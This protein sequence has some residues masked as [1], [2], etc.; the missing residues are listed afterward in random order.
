MKG[1]KMQGGL[2]RSIRV[3]NL[4]LDLEESLGNFDTCKAAYLRCIELGVATPQHVL[5]FSAYLLEQ[6]FFEEAFSAYEK[7][8]ALFYFPSPHAKPVWSEYLK[9]FHERYGG[10]KIER[11]RELFERC[12]EDC[13]EEFVG[14]YLMSYAALE[15]E[16]GLAKRALGVYERCAK[17]VPDKEKL[18]AYQL[19]IAK[20]EAFFGPT[21]TR[22]IYEAAIAA[23]Q[24]NDSAVICLAYADLEKRLGEVDRARAAMQ[25]GAQLVDP[26]R[27]KMGYWNAWHEFEVSHG[28]EETFRDMLRIKRSVSAAFSTVNYNSGEMADATKPMSDA[29]AIAMIAREEGVEADEVESRV[30]GFVKQ[31]DQ[32]GGKRKAADMNGANDIEALERQAAKIRSA[33]EGEGG[34]QEAGEDDIDL[35]DI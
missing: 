14:E 33:Q 23:L 22:P 21:A 24:D 9:Q 20:A 28:N 5:N 12:L 6:K 30:Q 4:Y 34:T 32:A 19:Y 7:G 10:T 16:H 15:D 25:F 13:P 17:L 26:G 27:D 2:Y 3:W 8:L 18:A 11:S 29:E 35:D 31:A 1:G